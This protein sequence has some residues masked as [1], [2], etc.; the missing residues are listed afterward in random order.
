MNRRIRKKHSQFALTASALISLLMVFVWVVPAGAT[1]LTFDQNDDGLTAKER[2]EIYGSLLEPGQGGSRTG[3]GLDLIIVDTTRPVAWFG[4]YRTSQM[5]A[6]GWDLY[7]RAVDWVNNFQNPA[8]TTVWLATYNGTLDPQYSAEKDGIAVYN[9]LINNMGFLAGNI[10]VDHQ[11][12]IETA[13]FTGY[14][15]VLYVHTYPRNATNVMNQQKPFLTTCAGETDELNI[16]TGVEKM[17]EYRNYGYIISNTHHI[18]SPYSKGQFTLANGM[19]MDAT[20][21]ADNGRVLAKANLFPLEGDMVTLS[22]ANGGT[23]NFYLDA[24]VANANRN[25]LILGTM[26]GTSPGYGLPGGIVT[27]PI[28]YDFFT[29]IVLL[30]LNTALFSD[31]LGVLDGSGTADAVLAAPPLPAGSAGITMH[32]AYCCNSPFDYVSNPFEIVIGP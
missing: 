6:P 2:A 20:E 27:L 21:V 19:W 24:G 18:T 25:Y 4:L 15:I 8:N 32:Y 1:S 3:T 7:E 9:Y 22:E 14:D 31:F 11:S 13:N 30:L 29:D 5:T 17:H 10:H 16:G 28:N 23:I 12:T 26:S